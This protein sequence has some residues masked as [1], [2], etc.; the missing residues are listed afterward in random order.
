MLQ[1][2]A[3]FSYLDRSVALIDLFDPADSGVPLAKVD[4][5]LHPHEIGEF[6]LVD[7]RG[8]KFIPK[9]RGSRLEDVALGAP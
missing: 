9:V 2:L 4:P 8:R 1:Q 3:M 7:Q 5:K 6:E